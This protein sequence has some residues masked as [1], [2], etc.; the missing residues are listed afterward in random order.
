[1][2][3]PPALPVDHWHRWYRDGKNFSPVTDEELALFT[4]H[5]GAADG[6]RLLD[7]GCGTGEYARALHEQGFH[8]TGIDFAPSAIALAR[9]RHGGREGLSFHQ[10]D[11]DQGISGLPRAGY[12]VITAR[13]A[14]AFLNRPRLRAA[15]RLLLSPGGHLVLTTPLAERLPAHR[16]TIG[17][18]QHDAEVLVRT[19]YAVYY[20][21]GTLRVFVLRR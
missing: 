10:H 4:D 7:V 11:I 5:L 17:I 15:A 6:R 12:D 2:P 18:T 9:E 16:R 8:V 21:L 1:M 19:W 14:Y 20:D 13:L 3:A